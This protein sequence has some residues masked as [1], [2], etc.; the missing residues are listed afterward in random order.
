[1]DSSEL[2]VSHR[3]R[4]SIP[5]G[6]ERSRSWLLWAFFGFLRKVMKF[7]ERADKWLDNWWLKVGLIADKARGINNHKIL[8]LA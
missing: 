3:L 6:D 1:M 4:F 8:P 7:R 5:P 2:L